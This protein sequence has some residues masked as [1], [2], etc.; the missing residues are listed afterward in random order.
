MSCHR[1]M[2]ATAES[3]A[4]DLVREARR[5]RGLSQRQLADQAGVAQSPFAR[6]ESG[7]QQ[8]TLPVLARLLEAAGL[9]LRAELDNAIRPSALLAAHRAEVL[10]SAAT[11][12][13]YDVRALGSVGRGEDRPDSDLDLLVKLRPEATA[14]DLAALIEDLTELLGVHVDVVSEGGLRLPDDRH[15]LQE[16]V[17]V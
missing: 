2:M 14:L 5:R 8:P 11:H 9:R 10:R 15:I 17:A 16:A 12:R 1:R 13:A 7:R 4:A 3:I 6:I